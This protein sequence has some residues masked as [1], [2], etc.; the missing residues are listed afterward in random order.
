METYVLRTKIGDIL[1][2]DTSASSSR[3]IIGNLFEQ[4]YYKIVHYIFIRI[5]D[6]G[7]AEDL[8]GEVFIR[9]LKSFGSF[10]GQPAQMPSW[11]FKIAHNLMVDYIRKSAIRKQSSLDHVEIHNGHSVEESVE[12]KME[13]EKLSTALKRLTP[14]Q[15]EVIGLRFF[16]GLPSAEVGNILGKSSGA[17]REMQRTAVDTLRKIMYA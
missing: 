3:A 10:R 5:N 7:D 11:L 6:R 16:A 2:A 8:G 12:T 1:L 14:A 15:R 13:I 9:A 17:V 4:Y